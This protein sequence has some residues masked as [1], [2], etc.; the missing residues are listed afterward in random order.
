MHSIYI[1]NVASQD[2]NLVITT[3]EILNKLT[4]EALK[5]CYFLHFAGMGRSMNFLDIHTIQTHL[6]SEDKFSLENINYLLFPNWN[7]S[8]EALSIGFEFIIQKLSLQTDRSVT[9]LIDITG[10]TEDEA[11]LFLSSV[12][13]NL[14]MEEDL[15]VSEN[16]NFSFIQNLSETEW[17]ALLSQVLA[18]IQLDQENLPSQEAIESLPVLS[19]R[20][21]N[22]LICPDWN[23]DSDRLTDDLTETLKKLAEQEDNTGACVLVDITGLDPETI[24]LYLSELVMTVWLN[25]GIDLNDFLN[26]SLIANLIP[27]QLAS[28]QSLCQLISLR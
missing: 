19:A 11:N 9:L 23:Q 28:L 20:Y 8:E 14:M 10:I 12:A 4:L 1:Y 15:E 25:E 16:L 5:N 27:D 21:P 26:I 18:R 3:Q 7:V 17:D 6:E 24:G 2:P 22:Y 13:L